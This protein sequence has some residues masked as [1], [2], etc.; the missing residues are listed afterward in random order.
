MKVLIVDDSY[1]V[2]QSLRATIRD[3]TNDWEVED[4]GFTG[5]PESLERF[6]P[7]AVVLDLVEGD[8]TEPA[9]GNHSFDQI[10][11]KWFCPVV[12]YSAFGDHKH[13][14]HPLVTTIPK[15]AGTD[16]Q[17][18]KCLEQFAEIAFVIRGVHR[19]F[20]KRIRTA[21]RDSVPVLRDQ[22]QPDADGYDETVLPRA[23]RRLVAARMDAE[24][25][26]VGK[27]KAWERFV[28]P[29]LGSHLLS[30]DLLRRKDADWRSPEAFRLVLTPSCDLVRHGGKPP[31][32]ERYSRRV[33]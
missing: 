33:L 8:V 15:G 19:E 1:A 18:V 30:A 13:F 21:L 29:A 3:Q 11:K 5:V 32:A 2:R 16:E 14:D 26:G 20:D 10:R 4:Q 7:D 6:R 22:I 17:V 27:L 31:K 24:S 25:S 23:V 12:V 28:V 9:A